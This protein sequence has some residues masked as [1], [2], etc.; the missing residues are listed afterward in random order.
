MRLVTTERHDA[1]VDGG[2]AQELAYRPPD[3]GPVVVP[4]NQP[5]TRG[6]GEI[7]PV[8]V[9]GEEVSRVPLL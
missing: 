9:D 7:Q 4:R 5:L 8:T 2:V 1:D 6:E 3:T